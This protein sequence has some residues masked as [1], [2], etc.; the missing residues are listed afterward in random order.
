[1]ERIL[2]LLLALLMPSEP[3]A[4]PAKPCSGRL[5]AMPLTPTRPRPGP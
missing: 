4:A 5:W 1:M 2:V 3:T